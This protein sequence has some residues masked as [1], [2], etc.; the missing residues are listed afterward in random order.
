MFC[1][2]I[3]YFQRLTKKKKMKMKKKKKKKKNNRGKP[4]YLNLL[5]YKIKKMQNLEKKMKLNSKLFKAH[6][7][8][9]VADENL[10]I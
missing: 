2:N 3:T 6:E 10:A 5:C 7:R 9:D 1:V 8:V 4:A